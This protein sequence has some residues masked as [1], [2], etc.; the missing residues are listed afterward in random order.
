MKGIK[1]LNRKIA[2]QQLGGIPDNVEISF[3]HFQNKLTI[4]MNG[5][6]YI[7]QQYQNNSRTEMEKLL[8]NV[9]KEKPSLVLITKSPMTHQLAET[10]D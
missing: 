2:D 10:G 1:N 6:R 4:N 5:I 9:D 8:H 7:L 3:N